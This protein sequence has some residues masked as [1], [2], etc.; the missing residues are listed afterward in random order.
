MYT[1]V[2]ILTI[3]YTIFLIY[4]YVKYNMDAKDKIDYNKIYREKLEISASEAAYLLN[5]RCDSLNIILADLLTL[6]EKG[7]L[8]METEG[9]GKERDYIFIKTENSDTTNLKG[10][11]MSV[12]RLFFNESGTKQVKIKEYLEKLK[13]DEKY[14]N[15]LE[16]KI[17]SIKNDI[18]FELR[19]R[20]ITDIKAEKKLF[21]FNKMSISLITIFAFG[22][23]IALFSTKLELIEFF[24]VGLLFSILLNITTGIKE[25]KLTSYGVKMRKQAEGFKNYLEKNVIAEDK[26]LYMVNVLEYNYIMAVAFGLAKLGENEFVHDTYRKIKVRD[27]IN[28]IFYFIIIVAII[29]ANFL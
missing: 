22:F 6:I 13:N 25:D 11:E 3:I 27:L 28:G 1:S 9:E 18:E 26:P 17:P 21:K 19:R 24:L 7:H 14:I 4:I 8:R 29:I 16:L 10:H 12:Y 2:T 15:E 20:G 5:K 23:I